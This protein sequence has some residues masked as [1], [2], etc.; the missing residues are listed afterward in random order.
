M[1]FFNFYIRFNFEKFRIFK[2]LRFTYELEIKF[3]TLQFINESIA[4]EKEV[5]LWAVSILRRSLL[6]LPWISIVS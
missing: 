6:L 4:K 1:I 5:T 2:S 3:D